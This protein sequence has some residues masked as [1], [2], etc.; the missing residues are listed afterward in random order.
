VGERVHGG[1]WQATK[2]GNF[3][4][5][6]DGRS[7]VEV[8]QASDIE[9]AELVVWDSDGEIAFRSPVSKLGTVE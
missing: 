9:E 4:L 6:I 3:G 8:T 1:L 2:S 5:N 7:V